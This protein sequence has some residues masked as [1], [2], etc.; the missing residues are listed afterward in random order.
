MNSSPCRRQRGV[1]L[2]ESATVLVIVG[3]LA[4]TLAANF[5]GAAERR[6]IEGTAAQLRTDI[7]HVSSLAV[8]RN[9][10]LR[11]S[12]VDT[13]AGSCYVGHTGAANT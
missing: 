13:P 6:S 2:V 12:F 9:Q 8:A 5:G 10:S 3:I 7:L 4:G 1:T 11:M